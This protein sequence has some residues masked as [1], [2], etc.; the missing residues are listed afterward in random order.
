MLFLST[1]ALEEN[2]NFEFVA[3]CQVWPLP[4]VV[5]CTRLSG[6]F[7][8]RGKVKCF[9]QK[10]H[11]TTGR[12]CAFDPITQPATCRSGT[13]QQRIKPK[14]AEGGGVSRLNVSQ[15]GCSIEKIQQFVASS[16]SCGPGVTFPKQN[17]MQCLVRVRLLLTSRLTLRSACY[18]EVKT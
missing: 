1:V 8:V 4:F 10:T 14:L 11:H 13:T 18:L 17:E 9:P 6:H 5:L 3:V 15:M 2:V 12:T 7:H 16:L